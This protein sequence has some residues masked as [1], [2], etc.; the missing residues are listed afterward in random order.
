MSGAK[1]ISWSSSEEGGAGK[2]GNVDLGGEGAGGGQRHSLGRGRISTVDTEGAAQ[3]GGK[4]D[5]KRSQGEKKMGNW[6]SNNTL[7]QST[8]QKGEK[9]GRD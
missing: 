4:S 2:A 6:N 1:A 7:T 5:S 9:G 3:T 8:F